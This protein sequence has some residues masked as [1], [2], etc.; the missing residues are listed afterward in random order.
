MAPA[1]HAVETENLE[2]L[3]ELI[4]RG[5]DVN[6][7]HDGLTLLHHAID[8]EIDGHTQTGDP[9]HVDVTAYL[10]ARGADPRRRSD[11][12]SGISAEHMALTRGH[13]LASCL[14]EEW[15]RTHPEATTGV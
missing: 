15:L 11:K 8:V 2:A 13:W 3:R 9:L 6:E 14:I 7:E 4:D 12:G 1:H 5:V 10:L